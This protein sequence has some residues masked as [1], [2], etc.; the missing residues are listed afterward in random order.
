MST[1]ANEPHDPQNPPPEQPRYG[2]NPPQ[3]GQ[4]APQYGQNVPPYGQPTPQYGQNAAQ[5]PAPYGQAP[6]QYPGSFPVPQQFPMGVKPVVA[7]RPGLLTAAFWLLLVAG[8]YSLLISVVFIILPRGAM[9]TQVETM[10]AADPALQSQLATAGLKISDLAAVFDMAINFVVVLGI[11][12]AGLFALIAFM[13]RAGSN[14]ARI[15]GTVL[16]VLSLLTLTSGVTILPA[17]LGVVA[18]VL[19]WL[20][21]S[22]DYIAYKKASR[23]VV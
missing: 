20:R 1:P 10:I 2:Q 12:S 18:I 14:G 22:S 9:L 3:A 5:A 16:A 13:L 8:A 21:P 6:Q 17:L 4:N 23:A 7:N 15:T 11:I 19:S